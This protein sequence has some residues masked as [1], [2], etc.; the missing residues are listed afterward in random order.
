MT[1][2]EIPRAVRVVRANEAAGDTIDTVS[3]D[4][5]ARLLRRKRLVADAGTEFLVDLVET[6]SVSAGDCFDIGNNRI[7]RIEAAPEDLIEI[8]GDLPRLAWH[9]GNR[10]TPCQVAGDCL[11]IQNDH[12]LAGMLAGLGAHLRAVRAP[13]S[14]EGGAYGHGRTFPHSHGHDHPSGVH[15]HADEPG[16]G[17]G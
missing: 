5:A 16:D 7:I 4:Y 15:V 14:P 13:F 10:H 1:T 11:L 17:D 6:T 12:V 3:L 9:I 8:K 2:A